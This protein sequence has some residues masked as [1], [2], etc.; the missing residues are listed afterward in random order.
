MNQ[1]LFMILNALISLAALGFLFWLIYLRKGGGDGQTLA[2][3]P[4]VNASLNATTAAFL[5]RGWFAIKAGN[6]RLHAFCMKSA[7]I[8][9]ALF[10]VCYIIYH[11]AHGDTP[12]PGTGFIRPI[13]FF[14]LISHILLSMAV[15]PMILGTFF[16]AL[17]RQFPTH[18]KWARITLP[19]WL[20][21]SL[22]GVLVFFLLKAYS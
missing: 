20:Y 6:Q 17:T 7:F 8:V 16:H 22:T 11:S 9:S 5:L 3:L 18:R 15:L 10:L 14:I 21:V 12:F 13:Y 2:F 19:I 4:A 1:R